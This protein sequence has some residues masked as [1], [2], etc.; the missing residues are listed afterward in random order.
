MENISKQK[1][2][3]NPQRCVNECFDNAGEFKI[4]H[5]EMLTEIIKI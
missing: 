3:A 4:F 2:C 5:I 1:Y